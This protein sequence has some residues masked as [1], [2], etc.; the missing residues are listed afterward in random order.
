MRYPLIVF[1]WDGTIIDSHGSIIECMQESSRDMGLPVPERGRAGH[2]IGLG[3]HDA[4]KIAAPDLR[5]ERYPEFVAHC[6]SASRCA[7]EMHSAC[8]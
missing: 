1:D 6:F 7:D 2:V 8:S 5:A 4:M 3:M